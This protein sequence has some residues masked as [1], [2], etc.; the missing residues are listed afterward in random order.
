MADDWCGLQRGRQE[1]GAGNLE[2]C[3]ATDSTNLVPGGVF[4]GM[5]LAN[6]YQQVLVNKMID[7]TSFSGEGGKCENNMDP[8]LKWIKYIPPH[9]PESNNIPSYEI[10]P[11][12]NTPWG[13]WCRTA[14]ERGI[15]LAEMPEGEICDQYRT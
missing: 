5:T 7:S 1:K 2:R 6:A 8:K 3:R 4:R 9:A 11:T 13:R 10:P 14:L 12:D 15:N